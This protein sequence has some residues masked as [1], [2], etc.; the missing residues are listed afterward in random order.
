MNSIFL[1]LF[2]F[3]ATKLFNFVLT[4]VRRNTFLINVDRFVTSTAIISRSVPHIDVN[5]P[6]EHWKVNKKV[7]LKSRTLFNRV[8]GSEKS[9]QSQ[10]AH[11]TYYACA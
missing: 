4:A 6:G 10:V 8:S 5:I 7:H 3:L 1:I 2:H 9:L 11:C